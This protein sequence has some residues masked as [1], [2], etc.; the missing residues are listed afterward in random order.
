MHEEQGSSDGRRGEDRR[1]QDAVVVLPD[2][3]YDVIVVSADVDATDVHRA[4]VHLELAIT[5]G[6]HKGEVV[7]VRRALSGGADP[8]ELL[9]L[10]GTL[11][12]TGSRPSLE[13]G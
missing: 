3:S 12:V 8:V 4:L 13:I 10:P 6:P 7:A 11:R 2:G 1:G 5:T 9:G